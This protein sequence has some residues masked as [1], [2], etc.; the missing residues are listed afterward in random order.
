MKHADE[1]RESAL[2][3]HCFVRF[4]AKDEQSLRRTIEL[5]GRVKLAK[6]RDGTDTDE[7]A[8]IAMMT[9]EEKAYFWNPT[10][11]E[12]AAWNEHWFATPVS[13]RLSA[14]MITPQWTL[15]SMLD[16]LWTGDYDLQ[17]ILQREEACYLTFMPHG[18]PYGG[19][20]C[21]IAFIECFGHTVE[22]ADDGTGYKPHVPRAVWRPPD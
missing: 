7:S 13:K 6:A 5:F 4:K 12:M 18:Y 22:G 10:P 1:R 15:G 8:I 2:E 9:D 17:D 14:E 16:S 3:G 20:G 11:D 19:V 21:M